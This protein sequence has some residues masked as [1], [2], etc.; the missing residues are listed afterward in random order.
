VFLGILKITL[1]LI[2]K[3]DEDVR[4]LVYF[5][6]VSIPPHVVLGGCLV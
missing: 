2:L 5:L 6:A 1:D 4:F 3:R